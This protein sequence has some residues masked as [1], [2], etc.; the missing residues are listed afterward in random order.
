MSEAPKI[1][2]YGASGYTGKLVAECLAQRNLPFYFV[3]RNQQKLE[4]A[5]AI[6][7]ERL[8][9]KAPATIVRASNDKAELAPLFAKVEVVINVAGPFMQLAWPVVE[10]C[11][12][13][14]C[15][16]LDTTGEQ[17]FVIAVRDKYGKAFADKNLLLN[18]ANSYMWAAGALAAEVVLET[19]GVDTL[20]ITYQINNALPSQASTKSFLRMV[21]NPQYMIK[22]GEMVEWQGDRHFTVCVPHLSQP[23]LALPW[24]GGC[25]PAWYEHD[26]RVRNCRVLTAFGDEII[27]NVVAVIHRFNEESKGMSQ[28]EKE[29]LTNRYG[30]EMT[31]A[32]PPKDDRDLHRTVITCIGQGRQV[33]T[34]F[35]LSLNAP[36][37]FTGEICAEAAQRLLNGQLKAAGFQSATGAFGHRELLQTFHE[38][39]YTNLPA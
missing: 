17:D 7:E 1:L 25:E 21:N 8:G 23:V 5:L 29:E 24:S 12:E 13:N 26:D 34:V 9:H 39:G 32:E 19:E 35:P 27:E 6:V 16:Y 2:I 15:H 31:P 28:E 14:N 10:A 11:L 36:Y 3:G 4:D 18:P 20:D 38:L 33:T 30:D 22:E 37:T